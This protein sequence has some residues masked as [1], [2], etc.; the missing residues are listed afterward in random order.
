MAGL[1]A[2]VWK[3][4]VV[5]VGCGSE[6]AGSGFVTWVCPLPV[7]LSGNTKGGAGPAEMHTRQTCGPFQKK[8]ISFS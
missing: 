6:G 2:V 1:R 5:G 7:L 4:R 8:R 3:H